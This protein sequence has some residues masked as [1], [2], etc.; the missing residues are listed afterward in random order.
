[1]LIYIIRGGQVRLGCV[2]QRVAG[3]KTVVRF[4]DLDQGKRIWAALKFPDPWEWHPWSMP[5][6][7]VETRGLLHFYYNSG[8]KLQPVPQTARWSKSNDDDSPPCRR[9]G[10]HAGP[11]NVTSAPNKMCLP[12][13]EPGRDALWTCTWRAGM[14]TA[15]CARSCTS[16]RVCVLFNS[17]EF[18]RVQMIKNMH[19]FLTK[20]HLY[21][22]CRCLSYNKCD[23]FSLSLFILQCSLSS[24]FFANRSTGECALSFSLRTE[25]QDAY[26]RRRARWHGQVRV[27]TGKRAHVLPLPKLGAP[28]RTPPIKIDGFLL[29]PK[30]QFI[31][32][33]VQEPTS[34]S[35][36]E[37]I[38]SIFFS[39]LTN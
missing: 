22:Q 25:A 9:F 21:T 11:I 6:C 7:M 8:F 15:L 36:K 3:A 5:L 12:G 37:T 23:F 10:W 13:N 33:S 19:G 30:L 17:I 29:M 38:F 20:N 2:T 27:V 26:E 1:M 18:I 34:F 4:I 39:F 32:S 24:G 16:T 31:P 14:G 35:S 28:L